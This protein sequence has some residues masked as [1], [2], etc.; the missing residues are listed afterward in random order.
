M[1]DDQEHASWSE[2]GDRSPLTIYD[3]DQ[4]YLRETVERS[5][6]QPVPLSI[7]AVA[8][9]D[10]VASLSIEAHNSDESASKEMSVDAQDH[11][12]NVLLSEAGDEMDELRVN[13]DR[14]T[15]RSSQ[16]NEEEAR[17]VHLEEMNRAEEE[18]DLEVGRSKDDMSTVGQVDEGAM[19]KL[20]RSQRV[21]TPMVE[22]LPAVDVDSKQYRETRPLVMF[23]AI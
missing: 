3:R 23:Q 17:P 7:E 6:S 5:N 19:A 18:Q 16:T 4:P 2:Q 13:N 14:E 11:T 20:S 8:D 15:M 10:V 22:A 1:A 9:I 21:E 12:I